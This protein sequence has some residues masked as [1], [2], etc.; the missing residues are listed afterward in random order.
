M[1]PAARTGVLCPSCADRST[2]RLGRTDHVSFGWFHHRSFGDATMV[3]SPIRLLLSEFSCR[4][5][6]FFALP[7]LKE[8]WISRPACRGIGVALFVHADDGAHRLPCRPV[9]HA[10]CLRQYPLKS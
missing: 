4:G 10:N 2:L 8:T 6:G 7:A 9:L 1:D 5:R 3:S